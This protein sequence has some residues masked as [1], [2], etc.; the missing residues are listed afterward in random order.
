MLEI[1]RNPEGEKFIDKAFNTAIDFFSKEE[2]YE[3]ESL[4]GNLSGTFIEK[5]GNLELLLRYDL[6]AKYME[7]ATRMFPDEGLFYDHLASYL[8]QT[9]GADE[10]R[11]PGIQ[12]KAVELEPDNDS[13]INKLGWIYLMLGN[14]EQAAEYFRQAVDYNSEN[15]DAVE[16]LEITE[17]MADH[18]VTYLQFL[19]QVAPGEIQ[20]FSDVGAFDDDIDSC[21]E[22]NVNKLKAFEMHHLQ[23]KALA[24]HEILNIL[25]PLEI[26][27]DIIYESL[28]DDADFSFE[29]IDLILEKARYLIYQF[30]DR[31]QLE[32]EEALHAIIRS[33]TVFY[34]FLREGN[35][36]TPDQNKRVAEQLDLLKTEF[37]GKLDKYYQICD[38]FTLDAEEKEERVNELF[39][40]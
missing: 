13:Y 11:L 16:N 40:I 9:P 36:I 15:S 28:E 3:D 34:D 17:Y 22:Y 23:K 24:P 29:N 33:L 30:L 10:K 7:E 25:K 5:T 8:L 12:Q 21:E 35:V 1:G 27:L 39:G 20:A 4:E 26:F 38:D 32:G 19:L 18:G 6:A 2:E 14:Y 37:S 31:S